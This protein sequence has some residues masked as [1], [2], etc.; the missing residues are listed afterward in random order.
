MHAFS[1]KELVVVVE[2][3]R[4]R[5]SPPLLSSSLATEGARPDHHGASLGIACT[6]GRNRG[7][8]REGWE[9]GGMGV[10]H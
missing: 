5:L 4:P 7:G 10:R 6:S 9:S 3:T 8:G 1:L 2:G